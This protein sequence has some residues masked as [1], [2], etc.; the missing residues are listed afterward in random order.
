M[1]VFAL[2]IPFFG[3]IV[4]TLT[5]VCW[6]VGVICFES[7]GRRVGSLAVNWLRLVIGLVYLALYGAIVHGEAFPLQVEPTNAGWLLA[8][9]LVGFV[10]GDL[11]LFRAFL[12]IGGRLSMLVYT[13][14]PLFT[15][16]FDWLIYGS[17]LTAMNM[18]GMAMTL[19]G[20]GLAVLGKRGGQAVAAEGRR[21]YMEGLTL[22]L[23]GS[24]GQ[25][26]GLILSKLGIGS[27]SPFAATQIR[28]VAGIAGFSLLFFAIGWWGRI[29]S[30]LHDK[31][32]MRWLLL[33]G[34]F[35]PFLGVSFSIMALQYTKAGLAATLNALTPV[36][37]I[38][39]A[40]WIMKE[41][42][43]V[44]AMIGALVAVAGTAVMLL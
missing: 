32:A 10:I 40:V 38:L 25:A 21:R 16:L 8:S 33:G 27:L 36:F 4:A 34:I 5:A 17:T 22:A 19:V 1:E 42:V 9:G 2:D 41:K 24:F 15:S 31:I 11:A 44:A 43:G 39:P 20:V 23:L 29:R 6:T 37:I 26:G 12:L 35:G 7:A 14:V 18:L 13:T 30:A 3:E 28:I